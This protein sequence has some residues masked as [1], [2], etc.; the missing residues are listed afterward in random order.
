MISV[1]KVNKDLVMF[2]L[3]LEHK[4]QDLSANQRSRFSLETI[5]PMGPDL[6][7]K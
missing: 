1:K 5:G 6:V 2:S 3:Y 4:V 7:H